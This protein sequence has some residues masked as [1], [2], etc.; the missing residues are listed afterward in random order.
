[1]P[2]TSLWNFINFAQQVAD[3]PDAKMNKATTKPEVEATPSS[4][5]SSSE[6]DDFPLVRGVGKMWSNVNHIAIVVEDVGRSLQFY[7]DV[8]GM[9]QI[10]RPNFDRYSTL[11]VLYSTL[12]INH[13]SKISF[14]RY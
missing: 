8:V 11:T 2:N 9:K 13:I 7:T 12:Y 1:M 4:S 14:I 5:S 6:D 3:Q 10:M